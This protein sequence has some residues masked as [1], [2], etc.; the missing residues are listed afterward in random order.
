LKKNAGQFNSAR[1]KDAARAS[2]DKRRARAKEQ[3]EAD[4]P[5]DVSSLPRNVLERLLKNPS[6]APYVQVQA[7]TALERMGPPEGEGEEW[8]RSVQVRPDYSPPTWDEVL[9]VA[10]EA[11]AIVGDDER[12]G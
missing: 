12:A 2:W 4:G 8:T 9:K 1:A 3:E 7:A 6:T 5:V 10:R 11:G